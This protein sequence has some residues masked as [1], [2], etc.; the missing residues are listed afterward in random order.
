M[1]D[2]VLNANL[3]VAS[4]AVTDTNALIWYLTVSPRLTP[5][6]SQCFALADQELLRIYIPIICPVELIYLSERGRIDAAL[7]QRTLALIATPN[8]SYALSPLDQQVLLK[9][10]AV[11]RNGVPDMPDRLV[12]A[13]ALAL[14]LPLLTSD[15]AIQLAA[16]VPIIW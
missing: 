10:S 11:P 8:G 3:P 9:V 15:H 5:A 2:A 13:T 4:D 7:L 16:V 1:S 14:G 6:A 12:T